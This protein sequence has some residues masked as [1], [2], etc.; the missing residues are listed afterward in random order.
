MSDPPCQGSDGFH[1][2]GLDGCSD[3][4]RCSVMSCF[5]ATKFTIFPMESRTGEIVA[6]LVVQFSVLCPVYE[7]TGPDFAPCDRIP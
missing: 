2:L 6:A 3:R 4:L 5:T 7:S 1:L